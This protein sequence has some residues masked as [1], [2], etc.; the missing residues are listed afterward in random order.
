M[1]FFLAGGFGS[2]IDLDESVRI[3]LLPASLSGDVSQIGNAALFGA[4][5]LLFSEKLK[6]KAR[7]L[8]KKS[9]QINLAAVPDFQQKFLGNIR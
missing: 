5:A 2:R 7:L 3:G 9:T 8:A 1:R 4:S 6:E